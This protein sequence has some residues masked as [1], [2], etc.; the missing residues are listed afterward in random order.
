MIDGPDEKLLPGIDGCIG[1]GPFHA[2]P[3]EFDLEAMVLH[4]TIV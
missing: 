3:T 2:R 1:L 4:H